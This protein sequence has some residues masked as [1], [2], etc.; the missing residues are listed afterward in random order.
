MAG[1]E[2][3]QVD[4]SSQRIGNGKGGEAVRQSG[5]GSTPTREEAEEWVGTLLMKGLV[6]HAG[7]F[8]LH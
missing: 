6:C 1:E 2:G 7:G 4:R 5:E 3:W 8:G